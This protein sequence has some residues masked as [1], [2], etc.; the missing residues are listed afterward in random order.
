[1]VL[2]GLPQGLNW[3]QVA[4]PCRKG[5]GLPGFIKELKLSN[6]VICVKCWRRD[7]VKEVYPNVPLLCR[8]CA[9]ILVG[10]VAFLEAHNIYVGLKRLERPGEGMIRRAEEIASVLD[11]PASV[12]SP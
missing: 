3:C 1:V 9:Y 7:G 10:E 5:A 6:A 12:N 11:I 4:P 2:P 8:S